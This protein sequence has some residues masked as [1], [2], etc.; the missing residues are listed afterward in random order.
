MFKVK[1][2]WT[3]VVVLIDLGQYSEV[4]KLEPDL[5]LATTDSNSIDLQELIVYSVQ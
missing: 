2:G 1:V 5:S 4:P 3:R